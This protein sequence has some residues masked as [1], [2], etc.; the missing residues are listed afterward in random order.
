MKLPIGAIKK[1]FERIFETPKIPGPNDPFWKS[2]R[3]TKIHCVNGAIVTDPLL[4]AQMDA[5]FNKATDMVDKVVV[6][7]DNILKDVDK[8]LKDIDKDLRKF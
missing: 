4:K 8:T 1:F 2:D 5:T 7:V 3:V 6:G